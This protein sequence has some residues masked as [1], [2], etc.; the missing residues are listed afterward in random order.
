MEIKL[1]LRSVWRK[2]THGQLIR[3]IS[4][5]VQTYLH[6]IRALRTTVCGNMSTVSSD[7][8]VK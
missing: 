2:V 7:R 1:R 8:V 3:V 5:C 4:Y 6:F